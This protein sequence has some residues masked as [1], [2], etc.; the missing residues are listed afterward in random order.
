MNDRIEIRGIAAGDAEIIS[1]AFRAAGQNASE[2]KYRNYLEEQ[3]EGKRVVIVAFIDEEFA[4]YGNVIWSS[5]YNSFRKKGIPE[6]SDLY[7]LPKYRRKGVATAIMDHAELLISQRSDHAGIG[8]GLYAD[9]GPAQSMYVRR[10]YIP[11]GF[12]ATYEW[13][14]VSGGQSVRVDDELV[15][16]L[17]KKIN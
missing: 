5:R 14:P 13:T 8:F 7:V 17:M 15:L 12:G 2:S 4:G 3:D 6:I 11:D 1:S 9:Y 10:G 16:W